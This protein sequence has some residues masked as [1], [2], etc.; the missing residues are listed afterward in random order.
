M[1]GLAEDDAALTRDML[2]GGRVTLLQPREGYRAT[3]DPLLLAAAVPA[4]AGQSVLELGCG[5]GTAAL[6]L[7]RRV[8]G[9]RVTGVE[10][11]AAYAA[12]ARR[13]ATLNDLP[14]E[15]VEGDVADLPAVVRR[16][17]FDH[18]MANPPW[19]PPGSGA[20]AGRG[21]RERGRREATPL[22]LWV[23]AM[24]RRL[25]SGGH[26][27]LIQRTERL[28][29]VLAAIGARLGAVRVLPLAG[30]TG[31][32]AERFILLGRKDLRTPF[33]LLPPLVLHEGARHLADRDSFT[34]ELRAIL[35][36]GAALE[37]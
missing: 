23:D 25:R 36:E 22:A 18:V 8:P 7:M 10:L 28:P 37:I 4:R 24:L 21:D 6:C 26:F 1:N 31:R 2:L 16:R 5:V 30:R 12:L 29:E 19:F 33:T 27:V 32:P 34:P 13:N 11:Q 9:V 17:Q 35:R 14:L 20:P 15:V 3:T